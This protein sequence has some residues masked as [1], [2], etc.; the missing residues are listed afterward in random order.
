MKVTYNWLKDFVEIKIPPKDLAE[1]LTMAGLEVTSLEEK[2]TDFVFEIEVTPNRADCLSVIGIARE[3]AA[4][5]GKKLKTVSS[6]K[7]QVSSKNLRLKIENKK[8]CPLYTAKIIKDVKVKPSPDWLRKRLELV[9]CRSINNVV[10]ITNYI[11]FAW[12]EPLHAFDLDKLNGQ[13]II[14]RRAKEKE[15]I[16][17]IDGEARALNADILVIADR[18]GPLAIAGVMGGK[19]SEVIENT[20]NILLEAAI[21]NPVI[22]RRSRQS[23]GLQ[24]ESSYRFER[25]IDLATAKVASW[26]AVKLIQDLCAGSLVKALDAGLTK[27]KRKIV[28]LSLSTL[29]KVLDTEIKAPKARDILEDLGF[30]V[31]ESSNH[32]FKVRIP[33]HRQDVSLE[34]DLIE[35]IARIYGYANIAQTLPKV[36]PHIT[37]SGIRDLVSA[38]KNILIGLGLNEVITYSLI[39]KDLLKD[40]EIGEHPKTIEILNPLSKEQEILRPSVI[41]GLASCI[42][43]NLNQ[44]QNYINIFEIA[45]AFLNIPDKPTEELVLGIALCGTKSL[46]LGQGMVKDEIGLLHLKGIIETVFKRLGIKDYHFILEGNYQFAVCLNKNRVGFMGQLKKEILERLDIKNKDIFVGELYLEKILPI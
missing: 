41:S 25:G 24:T 21:F 8:D 36:T 32:D 20:K 3:V 17:T 44:K 29:N 23:L 27:E 39:S 30:K 1:R 46:L 14:V 16:V 38:I 22:V 45:K 9:D 31:S 12:G 19:D 43:Y 2:D 35:E 26:Q 10:D 42:A 4:I 33:S 11:L 18:N 15:K 13:T 37:N 7:Y 5:T 6:I 40:L 34:I 28:N